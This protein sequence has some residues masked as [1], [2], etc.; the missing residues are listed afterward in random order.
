[1]KKVIFGAFVATTALLS[2]CEG[3]GL[4]KA[5]LKTEVDT[6]SYV[7]GV[8]NSPSEEEIKAYL[9]QAGCDSAYA[10]AFFKGLKDGLN[11]SDDKKEMAYQLGMQSGMQI[12]TRMFTG[13]EN[14]VFAGDSTR[15]LSTKQFLAGMMDASKGKS[16]LVIGKDT[17]DRQNVQPFFM[18]MVERMTAAANEKV[19]AEAKKKN[20]DFIVQ[21]SKEDGVKMLPQGVYYKVLKEGNG[22]VAKADQVVEVKYEGRLINGNVF[23]SSK[24]ETVKFRCDQVIKGWTIALTNMKEGSEWEVYI[25]WNLAYGANS[26]G[27]IPP[28][29]A[30]IFK[31]TVVK[32]APAEPK[33]AK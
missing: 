27:P 15:H 6:L 29:S 3:T 11:V 13:L 16:A 25:P 19:Y 32:V 30:L 12:K 22:V 20:E 14:Q 24:E 26:Q 4:P 8:A 23:D 1:M 17:L 5:D 2:A 9:M 33:A 21:K 10:D 31:I 18:S 28:Y 7:L